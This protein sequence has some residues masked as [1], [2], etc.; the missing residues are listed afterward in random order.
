MDLYRGF[1][2]QSG[3][4]EVLSLILNAAFTNLLQLCCGNKEF[5]YFVKCS[6]LLFFKSEV[7]K[8]RKF[9]SLYLTSFLLQVCHT[10]ILSVDW[11]I[12][13]D[14]VRHV[15]TAE[16]LRITPTHYSPETMKYKPNRKI[17]FGN[18][19][20]SFNLSVCFS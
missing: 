13:I 19:T 8:F 2:A 4:V 10:V 11:F 5:N 12:D 6:F 7:L 9:Q 3:E 18:Y 17:N 1:G 16:M 20:V 15:R 14:V